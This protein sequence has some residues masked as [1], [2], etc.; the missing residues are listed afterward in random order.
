MTFQHS[1]PTAVVR[2]VLAEVNGHAQ[3]SLLGL[4]NGVYVVAGALETM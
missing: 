2:W 4:K 3:W 1:L